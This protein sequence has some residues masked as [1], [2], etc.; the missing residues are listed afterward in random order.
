MKTTDERK[1]APRAAAI[2]VAVLALSGAV[3]GAAGGET[4]QKN[5][6]RVAVD[7]KIAPRD[8]PRDGTS[9]VS[10]TLSGRIARS[11]ADSVPPLRRMTFA[12]NRLGHLQLRGL[13]VCRVGQIQPSTNRE[14]MEACGGSLVG[15]GRFAADVALPEDS[16]FPS[17]GKMLA[18]NGR[19]RGRPAILAHIYGTV[20]AP[21]SYVL[22]FLIR[23]TQGTYGTVLEA[24]LPQISG[25]WGYITAM[26]M[27]LGRRFSYRGRVVGYLAAGCPAPRGLGS[28]LFPLAKTRFGFAGGLSVETT[29]ARTCKVRS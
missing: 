20:P 8:L 29:L 13:P 21:T 4:A 17:E 19:L 11:G 16:P 2:A 1:R 28:A 25:E 9:P 27:T 10:V 7:G 12:I 18:F 3:V 15:H 22:P 24:S 6:V 23:K 14:A 5:G 26:S